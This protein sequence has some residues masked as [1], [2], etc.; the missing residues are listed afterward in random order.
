MADYVRARF[1]AARIGVTMALFGLLAGLGIKSNEATPT[2]TV[3]AD[4]AS[5]LSLGKNTIGSAQIKQHSLLF[6]D[7]KLHQVPSYKEFKF[8]TTQFNEKWA[9]LDVGNLVHKVDVY[10]K[11]TANSTFLNLSDANAEFLHKTDTA[12]NAAKLAGLTPD[13][14]I[15]G[16]GQVVTGHAALGSS[17]SDVFILVGLLKASGRIDPASQ[18]P[19]YTLTNLSSTDTLLVNGDGFTSQSLKPGA[20]TSPVQMGDGSVHNLQVVIQGGT[21]AITV[22]LSQFTGNT[23]IGQAVV[24]SY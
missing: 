9:K 3:V 19:E 11:A 15:Q 12:D 7:M 13:Q 6:S 22:G 18:K 1:H 24:G 20:S 14:L 17:D 16:H 23:L 5:S 8:F 4:P 2:T 10:D 21:E